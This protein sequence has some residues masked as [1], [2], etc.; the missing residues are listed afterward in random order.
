MQICRLIY[1][2]TATADVVPNA[3]LRELEAKAATANAAAGI[4]G[5]L[6]LSGRTFLQVLEGS[7]GAVTE[8]FGSIMQDERH[9]SVELISAEGTEA[10]MFD[11]WNMRLVDLY[12]LPGESRSVL[13]R[14]YQTVDGDILV[15]DEVHR[16]YA[17]L[18][19]AR[20]LCL[21]TPWHGA[22]GRELPGDGERAL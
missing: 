11:D 4:T 19:D 5:L 20:H 16:V 14:K 7:R 9:H 8:L 22:S 15:P 10:R 12:D 18:L 6:L 17:L 13:V 3:M 21:S 2:S 1:R